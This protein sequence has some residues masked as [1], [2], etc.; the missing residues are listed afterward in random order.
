MHRAERDD[1]DLLRVKLRCTQ[2]PDRWPFTPEEVTD[3]TPSELR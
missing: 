1:G 3:R 2:Y